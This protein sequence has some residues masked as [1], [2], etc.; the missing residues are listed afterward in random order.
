VLIQRLLVL[1]DHLIPALTPFSRVCLELI[2]A[3]KQC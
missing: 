1:G 3:M 2:L